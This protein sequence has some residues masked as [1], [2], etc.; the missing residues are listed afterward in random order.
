MIYKHV[1]LTYYQSGVLYLSLVTAPKN[2]R[3]RMGGLVPPPTLKQKTNPSYRVTVTCTRAITSFHY[4]PSSLT[5]P[6][7]V[8]FLIILCLVQLFVPPPPPLRH[9]NTNSACNDSASSSSDLICSSDASTITSTCL[10]NL[11]SCACYR[12][13]MLAVSIQILLPSSSSAPTL[14]SSTSPST[15]SDLRL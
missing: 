8:P 10:V 4:V 1:F 9:R 5:H 14:C 6:F 12:A 15:S 3:T 7:L 2:K 11:C 13:R